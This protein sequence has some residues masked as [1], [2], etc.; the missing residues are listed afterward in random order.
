MSAISLRSLAA[1]LPSFLSLVLLY[2]FFW[3]VRSFVRSRLAEAALPRHSV[4]CPH[5][6]RSDEHGRKISRSRSRSRAPKKLS[7]DD[8]MSGR[9]I[10]STKNVFGTIIRPRYYKRLVLESSLD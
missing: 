2:S 3:L 6:R 5:S 1:V 7:N 4:G 10:R 8:A 9:Q